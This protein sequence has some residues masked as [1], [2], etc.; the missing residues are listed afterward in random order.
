M[1]KSSLTSLKDVTSAAE[2]QTM[3]SSMAQCTYFGEW[4]RGGASG[5]VSGW[6]AGG[7]LPDATAHILR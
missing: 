2:C 6:V 5:G 1:P 3:C 4:H 7:M